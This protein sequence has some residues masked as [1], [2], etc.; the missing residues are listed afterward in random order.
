[1]PEFNEKAR[2]TSV[3]RDYKKYYTEATY[4]SLEKRIFQVVDYCYKNNMPLIC[5]EF[6]VINE[7]DPTSRDN[8][9]S[10][11]TKIFNKYK[12]RSMVWDYDQKFAIKDTFTNKIPF[13]S[14]NKWLKKAKK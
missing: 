14:I 1:M 11:I 2:G 6:G 8:Y 4:E 3:E 13:K 9:F 5:T 12:I 10:D 7:A